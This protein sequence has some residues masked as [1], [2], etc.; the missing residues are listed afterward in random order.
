MEGYNKW[1]LQS[2][3]QKVS[4]ILLGAK[5]YSLYIS[6]RVSQKKSPKNQKYYLHINNLHKDN[7]LKLS[8]G[9]F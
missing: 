3:F 9:W 5:C 2:N 8:L 4:T 7:K 6:P 1:V